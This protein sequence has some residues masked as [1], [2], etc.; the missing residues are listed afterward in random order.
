LD[1]RLAIDD[2]DH[3]WG[4]ERLTAAIDRFE[5]LG[6]PWERALTVLD[7]GRA[8]LDAGRRDEAAASLTDARE[9]FERLGAVHDLAVVDELLR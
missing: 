2:G 5:E 1:G 8:Q 7:L 4:I 9:T 3:A 6:I